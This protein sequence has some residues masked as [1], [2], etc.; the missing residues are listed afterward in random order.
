MNTWKQNECEA[1]VRLL[2]A[3]RYQDGKLSLSE[4][5]ALAT[6]LATLPWSSGTSLDLFV[7]QETARVRQ[8]LATADGRASF[9]HLQCAQFTTAAGKAAALQM[10]GELL[11]ADGVDTRENEYLRQIEKLLI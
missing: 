10:V 6:R 11:R 7:Q 8:A 1:V 4:G 2:L 5:D 9:L 3:A